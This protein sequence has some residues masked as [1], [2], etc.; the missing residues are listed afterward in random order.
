MHGIFTCHGF[1]SENFLWHNVVDSL[2]CIVYKLRLWLGLPKWFSSGTRQ[3]WKSMQLKRLD[4]LSGVA[5]HAAEAQ[6][7][8]HLWAAAYCESEGF[9]TCTRWHFLIS[10][11][12]VTSPTTCSVVFQSCHLLQSQVAELTTLRG[13]EESRTLLSDGMVVFR[14][15]FSGGSRFR[16][17]FCNCTASVCAVHCCSNH[18]CITGVHHLCAVQW[19]GTVVC[20]AVL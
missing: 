6:L 14:F 7:D 2:H 18:V 13:V 9:E 17:V 4:H 20:S 12:L 10:S 5:L 3:V 11:G 1:G 8:A 15:V 16:R 19:Y